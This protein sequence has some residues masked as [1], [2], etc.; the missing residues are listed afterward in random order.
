[1]SC[2]CFAEDWL[3]WSFG[4]DTETKYNTSVVPLAERVS[5]ATLRNMNVTHTEEVK[6]VAL[7]AMNSSING[8]ASRGIDIFYANVFSYW[9]YI[10]QLF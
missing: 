8:N 1:E 9:L 4:K 10:D 2:Y 3:A 7:S 5:K 6:V